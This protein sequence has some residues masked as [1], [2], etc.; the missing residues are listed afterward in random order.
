MTAS[1]WIVVVGGL[2]FGYW[3]VSVLLPDRK[4][5]DVGYS[6]PEWPGEVPPGSPDT[7][8]RDRARAARGEREL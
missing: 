7:T 6:D 2:A 4:S 8:A 5:D 3:V 1:E